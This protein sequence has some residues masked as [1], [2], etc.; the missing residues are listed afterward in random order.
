VLNRATSGWVLPVVRQVFVAPGLDPRHLPV[1]LGYVTAG[2][3]GVLDPP[4]GVHSPAWSAQPGR[5]V[6]RAARDG[7]TGDRSGGP[8]VLKFRLIEQG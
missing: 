6:D 4:P 2:D 1:L 8:V 3:L 5:R 7:T